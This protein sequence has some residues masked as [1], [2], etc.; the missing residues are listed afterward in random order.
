MTH[1]NI[2]NIRQIYLDIEKIKYPC[3]F[4]FNLIAHL[5]QIND[6]DLSIVLRIFMGLHTDFMFEYNIKKLFKK[7]IYKNTFTWYALTD[8]YD[9]VNKKIQL[10]SVLEKFYHVYDNNDFWSLSTQ[11][12]LDF[13][14]NI[15]NKFMSVYD[16]AKGGV[17]FYNKITQL[18]KTKSIS[19]N[20]VMEIVIERLVCVV[21]LFGT[22]MLSSI[23]IQ[24]IT[25]SDFYNLTNENVLIYLITIYEKISQLL[26]Q[27]IKLFNAYNLVCVQLS[28]LINPNIINIKTISMDSETE[29][30]DIKIY[31]SVE[32]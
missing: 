2:M 7:N 3:I 8:F 29:A 32:N 24:L 6:H 10:I 13:L 5:D 1:T 14:S 23:G 17:P 26:N 22:K 20:E 25:V 4:L 16:C 21:D 12:Q 31:S 9:I 19:K 28:N 18:F 27:T 11:D 15:K 30:E